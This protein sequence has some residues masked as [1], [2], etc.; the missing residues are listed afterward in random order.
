M[1]FKNA[2]MLR[3]CGVCGIIAPIDVFTCILLA[4][5]YA[6]QFSWTDNALSDLG[7]T[8]GITAP[9][10]NYG[11]I[12]G[13]VVA[14]V[15][16]VGLF[17]FLNGKAL[18]KIGVFFLVMTTLALISIGVFPENIKPTHYYV[19]VAFF[20][21][22]PVSMLVH[23]AAFLL[24]NKKRMGLFTLFVAMVAAAPWILYF[25]TRFVEGVAIPETVSAIS[26]S[27]WLMVL[28]SKMLTYASQPSH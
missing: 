6:P 13:G 1:G 25:A 11:L 4:I 5:N 28:G 24:S 12:I 22:F 7:V 14:L 16:A 9:L 20:L 15:F 18:S 26:A 19:S 8:E 3:L 23:A 10:F 21:L 17:T 27:A 2:W